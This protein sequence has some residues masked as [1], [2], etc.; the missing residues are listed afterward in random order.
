M[1]TH[2]SIK[3]QKKTQGKHRFSLKTIEN[4]MKTI[5]LLKSDE[6]SDAQQSVLHEKKAEYNARNNHSQ[7]DGF[8]PTAELCLK[9]HT[10]AV[11]VMGG[12]KTCL[13]CGNSK[14]S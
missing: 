4:H 9:C 5:G 2:I 11:I 10:K 13:S 3:Q 14:C 6:L 1:K 12:C 7:S 8:P